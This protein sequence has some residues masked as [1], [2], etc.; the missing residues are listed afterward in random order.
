MD[1]VTPAKASDVHP[2]HPTVTIRLTDCDAAVVADVTVPNSR[3]RPFLVRYAGKIYSAGK[4]GKEI[5]E[6]VEETV[7][8]AT[9]ADKP[10]SE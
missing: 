7:T 5:T 2:T 10:R 6:Y 4:Y 9:L 8:E 3:I 1:R